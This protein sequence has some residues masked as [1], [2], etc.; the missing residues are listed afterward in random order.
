MQPIATDGVLWS[1]CQC[2]SVTT[3]SP[4]KAGVLMVMTFGILNWLVPRSYVLDG[5]A[6]A[7]TERVT[8]GLSGRLK[9][10]IKCR[11]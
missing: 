8:F 3:V 11:I 4:A 10:I 1:V 7:P 6:D 9:S 2:L 5:S